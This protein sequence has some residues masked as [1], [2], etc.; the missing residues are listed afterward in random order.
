MELVVNR[1]ELS[2][3]STPAISVRQEAPQVAGCK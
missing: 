3:F 2:V 1:V